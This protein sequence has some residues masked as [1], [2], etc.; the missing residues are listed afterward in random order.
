VTDT[1][2]A[3]PSGPH[4]DVAQHPWP[5]DWE[6]VRRVFIERQEGRLTMAEIVAMLKAMGLR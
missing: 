5:A 3:L 4:G 1:G 6:M 2:S